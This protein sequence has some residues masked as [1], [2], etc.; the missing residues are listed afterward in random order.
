M[1]NLTVLKLSIISL[2]SISTSYLLF[3]NI[4]TEKDVLG[5]TTVSFETEPTLTITPEL[6]ITRFLPYVISSN[7]IQGTP[8][9]VFIELWGK[10]GNGNTTCWD[11]YADGTCNSTNIIKNMTNSSGTWANGYIHIQY[12]KVIPMEI[13]PSQLTQIPLTATT[14]KQQI[15]HL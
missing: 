14:T 12:L 10:N 15:V 11:Y 2:L 6:N 3:N 5:L 13:L 4:L 8:E 7:D 9:S 1:K